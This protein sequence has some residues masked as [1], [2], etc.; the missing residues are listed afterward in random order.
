MPMAVVK[1]SSFVVKVSG[2]VGG[3]VFSSSKSTQVVRANPSQS[4]PARR[5]ASYVKATMVRFNQAW[6]SLTEA[7]RSAWRNAAQSIVEYDSLG[8]PYNL[9]GSQYYARVA[10][11]NAYYNGSSI[12]LPPVL[13]SM[14]TARCDNAVFN[15][16]ASS[17]VLSHFILGSTVG[18]WLVIKCSKP[19][20]KGS[21][22]NNRYCRVISVFAPVGT[23]S[24]LYSAYVAV[25]GVPPVGS[26]IFIQSQIKTV[27]T[28]QSAPVQFFSCVV[29]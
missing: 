29:T 17:F 3:S 19:C 20:S 7:Q 9:N 14:P 1:L 18:M 28:G 11:Q 4:N 15:T 2:K 8:N 22:S 13:L 23:S 6:R 27:S 25:Y 10:F 26:R 21:L 5:A 12:S 16:G 24:N